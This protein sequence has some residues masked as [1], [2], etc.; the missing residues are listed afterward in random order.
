MRK[1]LLTPGFLSMG[2]CVPSLQQ[3]SYIITIVIRQNKSCLFPLTS[4]KNIGTVGWQNFL[5]KNVNL[6]V[7]KSMKHIFPVPEIIFLL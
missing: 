2:S 4:Q 3:P 5:Y 6:K 7:G 1:A